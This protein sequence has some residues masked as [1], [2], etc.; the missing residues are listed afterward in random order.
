MS[1]IKKIIRYIWH[2]S[3]TMCHYYRICKE[4]NTLENEFDS[5]S[6]RESNIVKL[7]NKK[8]KVFNYAI[9]VSGRPFKKEKK[10][11]EKMIWNAIN[12][13]L[14]DKEFHTETEY[15]KSK[16]MLMLYPYEFS[17][18]YSVSEQDVFQ[19]ENPRLKYVRYKDGKLYFPTEAN[20]TIAYKY[21]QL[22]ME[23]DINSPHRY[24]KNEY[25]DCDVFVDVGSAEGIISYNFYGHAK[26]IYLLEC[27]DKWI[28][29]LQATFT[30][31]N[32]GGRSKVHII[33]K[34]AGYYDDDNNITLDTLLSKYHGK[35]IVIKMDIE[36]ME[37][38]ALM[39]ASNTMADNDCIFSCTTYH[40]NSAAAEMKDFFEKHG[41]ST[42][43][44]NNY[45]LF[46]YGYMTLMNG[47]YQRM[48]Y[49]YF[50]HGI[51]RA[52]KRQKKGKQEK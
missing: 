15:I 30:D 48:Q 10:S 35:R 21:Y 39:G 6:N 8:D 28:E 41:Y 49:P 18:K 4:Y 31:R 29:A 1:F 36:G 25:I 43:Y 17:E 12:N 46:I 26:E 33:R 14:L 45:M 44:T 11:E 5:N 38:D 34:Y 50:R 20:K 40:T 23:Q 13:G 7:K 22:I 3:G 27:S 42:E 51:I 32:R 47:K 37:M 16:N 2:G 24:F 9:R 52:E 19:S